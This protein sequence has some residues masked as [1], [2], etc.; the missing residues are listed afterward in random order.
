MLSR[1]N[2]RIKVLQQLYAFQQQSNLSLPSLSKTLKTDYE[3]VYN[4]YYFSLSF[5]ENLNDFLESERLIESEKYFPSKVHIRKTFFIER[6]GFYNA[7]IDD[8]NYKLGKQRGKFSWKN[9]GNLFNKFFEDIVQYDFFKEFDLFEMPEKEVQ[10]QFLTNLFELAFNEF[11][12]FEDA[13]SEEYV[14]WDDDSADVLQAIIKC[15]D[16]FYD[17]DKI[18]VEKPEFKQIEG[19]GFGDELLNKCVIE[20]DSFNQ[21]IADNLS[22]WDSER[23]TIT[24]TILLR[25]AL[26]EFIHF[27]TIPPKATINEYLDIAKLYSTPKSHIFLNGVLDKIKIQLTQSGK[28]KKSG[29]G[30]KTE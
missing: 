18:S 2:I 26:A 10:K 3:N 8:N 14:L 20:K 17:K 22:N 13:L 7:L 16:K 1:R 11:E 19:M 29:V 12:L 15:V 23:L 5:L 9:H 24:D 30:L 4:I 25:M 27:E 21:M 28:M 6:L